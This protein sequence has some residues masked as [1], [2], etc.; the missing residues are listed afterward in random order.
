MECHNCEVRQRQFYCKSC[1]KTHLRDFHS[2]HTHYSTDLKAVVSTAQSSLAS[3]IEPARNARARVADIQARV[4]QLVGGLT[5][6]RKDCEKKRDRI[7]KLREDLAQRRRTLGAAKMLVRSTTSA[8]HPAPGVSHS[9]LTTIPIPPSPPYASLLSTLT[10]ARVG[11][12]Q[13]L[14][15]VFNIVE[16]GGRPTIGGRKGARGEWTI[17]SGLVL[18]VPGDIRRYPP[19]HINAVLTL[20]LHFINLLSFYL[21]VKLPFEVT[22]SGGKVGLGQPW[23]GA[24]K[25]SGEGSGSWARWYTKHPLHLSNSPSSQPPPPSSPPIPVPQASISA[26]PP[27]SSASSSSPLSHGAPSFTIALAMLIY[28]VA[29]LGHTQGVDIPLHQSGEVLSNLW[30]VC[31]SADVGRFGHET[32]GYLSTPS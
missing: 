14:V 4:E 8:P 25:G 31:C 21:G 9:T 24:I 29:Y 5:I 13:E 15:D 6:A 27:S 23:I 3:T 16:V 12:I 28:N 2:Q 26:S 11:L 20:T 19:D 22:W 18:P 1:L 17:G 10:R 32:G 7:R 30:R